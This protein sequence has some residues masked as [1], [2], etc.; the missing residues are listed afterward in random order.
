MAKHISTVGLNMIKHWEELRLVPY[1]DEGGIWTY[2]WGRVKGAAAA[3]KAGLSLVESEADDFLRA[4]LGEAERV[5]NLLVTVSITQNQFDALGVFVFN[6]GEGTPQHPGFRQSDLLAWLNAG[7]PRAPD[8]FAH[9][10]HV[11]GKVS[12]GL[13]NR[14]A[15]ERL[16]FV[17]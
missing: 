5:V 8:G 4:D 13:V 10:C 3:A 9:F 14:R 12:Q 16:L 15:S 2:G 1:R 11:D 7:D 17:S 6:V